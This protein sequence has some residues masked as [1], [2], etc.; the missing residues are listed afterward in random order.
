MTPSRSLPRILKPSLTLSLRVQ[1][2]CK[3]HPPQRSQTRL[4]CI[5]KY[6][7]KNSD[8]LIEFSSPPAPQE[9][10]PPKVIHYNCVRQLL[11]FILYCFVC[12]LCAQLYIIL[13]S[14]YDLLRA[15]VC[16]QFKYSHVPTRSGTPRATDLA[17]VHVGQAENAINIVHIFLSYDR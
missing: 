17:S 16:T 10:Q 11:L 12:V 3:K 8:S 1:C 2:D 13:H 7:L 14:F 9:D 15:H 4:Q 5:R 6:R